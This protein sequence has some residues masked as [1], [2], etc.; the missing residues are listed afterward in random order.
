MNTMLT[1][2]NTME[3]PPIK[4]AGIL[5]GDITT[6]D[7][8]LKNFDESDRGGALHIEA[9]YLEAREGVEAGQTIVV[10]FWLYTSDRN[11]LSRNISR[12]C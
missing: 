11:V 2:R 1:E 4:M 12:T 9:Q 3:L 5:R 10:L 7:D 8:A 6:T